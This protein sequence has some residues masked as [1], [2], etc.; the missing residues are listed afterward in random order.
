MDNMLRTITF[1]LLIIFRIEIEEGLENVQKVVLE[2]VEGL[3]DDLCQANNV[4]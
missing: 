4:V 2:V 1:V 3:I